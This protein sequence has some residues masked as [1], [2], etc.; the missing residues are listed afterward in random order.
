[1]TATP[2]NRLARPVVG[3]LALVLV[4][5]IVGW[6]LAQSG[7]PDPFSAPPP[8]ALGSGAAPSGAHCAAN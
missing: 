6:D 5:T 7:L 1:M 3:L 2:P 4:G 8:L